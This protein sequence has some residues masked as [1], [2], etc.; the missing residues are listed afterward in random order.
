[1]KKILAVLLAVMLCAAVFAGCG[2]ENTEPSDSVAPENTSEST[3]EV[4]GADEPE[5]VTTDG[6]AVAAIKSAGKLIMLTEAGFAPYEYIDE[7]NEVAGVDVE[8]SQA[9]A[10]KLGVEL[11]VVQMD[12]DGIVPAVQTG[13]GDLGAAG[14]TK[15]A[16][17]EKSVDFSVNYV[18]A[19]QK[20]VVRKDDTTIQGETSDELIAALAGK[21]VGVQMG[22]TGDIFVTDETEATPVQYKKYADA[23]L[24]LA[25]G[26]LDAMVVDEVPAEQIVS[27]NGDLMVLDVP[28]TEEQYAIAI[29][30]DKPDLKA[31]VDE[32][33]QELLDEGKIDEWIT[34]HKEASAGK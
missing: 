33:I 7:N 2:S 32:V 23:A 20:I 11:E 12:F 22:T 28:L 9:I 18:D 8:I 21:N 10:D 15:D 17:R 19:A 29:S 16:E 31:V 13:K 25:N 24:E 4:G 30:K 14:I 5:S 34:Q 3:S 27:A 6:E 26:K 1:M